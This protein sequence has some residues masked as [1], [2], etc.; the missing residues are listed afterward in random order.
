VGARLTGFSGYARFDFRVDPTGAPFIIDINPNPYLTLDTEDAAA[1]AEVGLSY[2]DL[3]GSI[4]ENS[5]GF[6]QASAR[7]ASQLRVA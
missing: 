1:A 7:H 4:V 6:S 3:I 2:Q 5:L